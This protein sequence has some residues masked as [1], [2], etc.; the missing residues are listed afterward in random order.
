MCG[1]FHHFSPT[2]TSAR[3][4][5]NWEQKK[6]QPRPRWSSLVT[7]HSP[8]SPTPR[9]SKTCVNRKINSNLSIKWLFNWLIGIHSS[10][11]PFPHLQCLPPIFHPSTPIPPTH[12][13]HQCIHPLLYP[14]THFF[15]HP[16][17]PLTYPSS[18]SSCCRVRVEC[19]TQWVLANPLLKCPQSMCTPSPNSTRWGG[20]RRGE[21]EG[22]LQPNVG[23]GWE[24]E[25]GEARG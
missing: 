9:R 4:S 24:G 1:S 3:L 11:P 14:P 20:E 10:F 12:L 16:T 15:T 7:S 23:W 8:V 22:E 19:W 2:S 5:W 21:G 6:A 18:T 17:H 25:E 13:P